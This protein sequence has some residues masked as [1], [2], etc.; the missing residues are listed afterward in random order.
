[1]TIFTP[2]QSKIRIN[3]KLF[4]WVTALLTIVLTSVYIYNQNVAF[5]HSLS[6]LESELQ[7]LQVANA[8]VKNKL[9]NLLDSKNLHGLIEKLS[10]IKETQPR[11][12]ESNLTVASQ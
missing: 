1:M 6:I 3:A 4:L 10:L 7:E 11:Y 2:H 9:Y 12:L 5:R 8:D